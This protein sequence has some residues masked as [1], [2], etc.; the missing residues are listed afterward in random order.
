[1]RPR[2]FAAENFERWKREN[3]AY[4]GFN[5]AAAIRRGKREVEGEGAVSG[6]ASMR[7]RRFAAENKFNVW[8]IKVPLTLQ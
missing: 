8:C 6:S 4:L 7:P 2:R 1:M 5:E 3:A